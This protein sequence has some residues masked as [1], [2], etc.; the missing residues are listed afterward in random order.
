MFW[1]CPLSSGVLANGKK[2]GGRVVDRYEKGNHGREG[3]EPGA[4]GLVPDL[5]RE[6]A[7][8]LAEDLARVETEISTVMVG[9][10]GVIRETLIALL[11]GGHTLLEGL[12]GLGKTVLVKTIGQVLDLTFSRIQFTP[13]LMPADITGTT[14]LADGREGEAGRF[15]F[16]PGPIFANAILADEINRATPKTQSALLEAMQEHTVTVGGVSHELPAPF[17]VLAT[18][19]PIEMEGTY[20]LPE[21]QLDR[22]LFKTLVSFPMEE[23]LAEIALR[24]TGSR[25]PE[26][27]RILSRGRLQE[28]MAV[29][30]EVPV[31]SPVMAY[32]SRLVM[33]THPQHEGAPEMVRKYVRYGASPRGMQALLLAGKA[34]ALLEGRFNVAYEDLRATAPPAFRHRLLLNF[35]GQA[36]GV[37]AD[38]LIAAI[39]EQVKPGGRR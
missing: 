30:R 4:S 18:Q 36:E 17:F 7:L 21:A 13:D 14:V 6:R 34:R 33:A 39:L 25:A 35:E 28:L 22:F 31:A 1:A 29:M 3:P 10:K 16:E 12:P 37:T 19:N 32:A 9:Q 38:R 5:L 26:A 27:R 23:E 20:P 2:G 15:N 11:A 24:T 8:G